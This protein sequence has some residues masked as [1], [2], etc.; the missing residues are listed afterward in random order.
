MAWNYTFSLLK[1]CRTFGPAVGWKLTMSVG[2]ADLGKTGQ[3]PVARCCLRFKE[4]CGGKETCSIPEST[5]EKTQWTTD[6]NLSMSR[7]HKTLQI[8]CRSCFT[9]KSLFKDPHSRSSCYNAPLN[10]LLPPLQDGL[11][12]PTHSLLPP[13]NTPQKRSFLVLKVYDDPHTVITDI[14]GLPIYNIYTPF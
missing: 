13:E 9:Q 4:C 8:K 7:M 3:T 11:C 12:D 1:T 14:D 2:Q 10:F 6:N 5:W